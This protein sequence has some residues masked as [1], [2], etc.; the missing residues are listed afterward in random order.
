ML[1][2]NKHVTGSTEFFLANLPDNNENVASLE[3]WQPI[4]S[5]FQIMDSK[6]LHFIHMLKFT[7]NSYDYFLNEAG[8]DIS[9][10]VTMQSSNTIGS[11]PSLAKSSY[12]CFNQFLVAY[13][14]YVLTQKRAAVVINSWK[15]TCVDTGA[16]RCKGCK[17]SRHIRA[18]LW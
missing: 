4:S 11:K 15:L 5:H 18:L 2:Q 8:W 17:I 14:N 10:S 9:C 16:I 3:I 1:N 7:V 13:N 6:S 12:S